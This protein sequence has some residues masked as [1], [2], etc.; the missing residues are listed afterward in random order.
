MRKGTHKFREKMGATCPPGAKVALL[1][2]HHARLTVLVRGDLRSHHAFPA[3]RV[4]RTNFF[5]QMD[6]CLR[7]VQTF[8]AAVCAIH[9]AVAAVK[10]HCVVDPSQ[11]FL[12]KLV[13]GVR[14]PSV[15][16]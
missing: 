15:S 4:T 12:G 5:L 16:L 6:N 3:I 14:N 9:N 13:T 8:W 10:L 11:T 1:C 7:W 2:V